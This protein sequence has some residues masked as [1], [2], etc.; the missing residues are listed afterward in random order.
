M[1]YKSI[2][3]Q[4]RFTTAFAL[5]LQQELGISDGFKFVFVKKFCHFGCYKTSYIFFFFTNRNDADIIEYIF[6][7]CATFFG[8]PMQGV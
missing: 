1:A 2:E 4:Q 5:S 7:S 3:K 8:F 6:V